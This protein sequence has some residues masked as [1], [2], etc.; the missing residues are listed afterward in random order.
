M[1]IFVHTRFASFSEFKSDSNALIFSLIGRELS[2]L[3]EFYKMYPEMEIFHAAPLVLHC[4]H[5]VNPNPQPPP[6]SAHVLQWYKPWLTVETLG[7]TPCI[8]KVFSSKKPSPL[9]SDSEASDEESVIQDELSPHGFTPLASPTQSSPYHMS[10]MLF[11]QQSSTTV[12]HRTPMLPSSHLTIHVFIVFIQIF[13]LFVQKKNTWKTHQ[14]LATTPQTLTQWMLTITQW[15]LP[16]DQ[17]M[18]FF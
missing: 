13:I 5:K 17:Q 4:K 15:T 9:H 10:G 1:D 2:E 14:F 18:F 7:K 16:C 11:P 12:G 3:C 6:P 8:W